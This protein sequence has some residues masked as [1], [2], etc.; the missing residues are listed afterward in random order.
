MASS[1]LLCW[2]IKAFSS[3]FILATSFARSEFEDDCGDKT[4][5]GGLR[6]CK[7]DPDLSF[8]IDFFNEIYA[9]NGE[10][11]NWK[12]RFDRRRFDWQA[13]HNI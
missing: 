8:T 10:T 1:W 3:L 12:L 4:A 5:P 6:G 9:E 7:T 13:F 2:T 11:C